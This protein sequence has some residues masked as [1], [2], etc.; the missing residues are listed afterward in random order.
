MLLAL[1]VTGLAGGSALATAPGTNGRIAFRRYVDVGMTTSAIFT[2]SPDGGSVRQVTHPRPGVDDRRP[3]WSPRGTELAFVR[4]LPCPAGGAKDGLDNTC[5]LVYTVRATGGRL[6]RVVGC[7]FKVGGATGAP[8]GDCVGVDDPAWSPDGAR[9]AFQY[10]LADRAFSG[11]LNV[12]AGIWTVKKD[13]SGLR[14]VTQ[15]AP[16]TSWDSGPSWSPDARKLAFV[17]ADLQGD[18][19]AIFTVNADGSGLR[20]VT[21]WDVNGGDRTDWSPDGRWILFRVTTS[22]GASNLYKVH[23]DGTGLTDLTRQAATGYHYLSGSF[24]PDRTEIVSSRT[25]GAGPERAADV[26]VMN[27]DGSSVRVLMKT[28]RWESAADWGSAPA[29]G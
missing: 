27:A 2:S 24:S 9:I 3:D 11:S 18:A 21:P 5:D 16:G 25:P 19:D 14:Q 17:R 6:R 1:V 28:R 26:V 8:A 23:P 7:R 29:G 22:D 15:R 13:G 12:S 20:Q 4:K 10:N